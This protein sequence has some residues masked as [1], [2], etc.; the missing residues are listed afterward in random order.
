MKS[1]HGTVT[2]HA[3]YCGDD[4][5]FARAFEPPSALRVIEMLVARGMARVTKKLS[6]GSFRE[7]PMARVNP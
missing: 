3:F 7:W 6:V 4:R 1:V 2:T 5:R